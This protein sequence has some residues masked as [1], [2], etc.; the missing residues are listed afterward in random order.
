MRRDFSSDWGQD[1]R[2]HDIIAARRRFFMFL[3]A[4]AADG[5]LL[6]SLRI[7]FSLSAIGMA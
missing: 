4:D 5:L 3:K 2:G 1:A 6:I 7:S